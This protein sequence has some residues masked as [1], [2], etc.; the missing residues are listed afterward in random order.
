MAGLGQ[1]DFSAAKVA[2]FTSAFQLRGELHILGIMQTFLNDEQ[3]PTLTV[4]G[5]EAIGLEA[6]SPAR[7]SQP[8]IIVNKRSV[9]VILFEAMPP[10]GAISLLPR[11]ESLV[12]YLDRFAL[13][14]KF[15]MGQDARI[16]DFAD[17]SV[18]QFLVLSEAKMFPMFQ[19]RQGLATS[20]PLAVLHKS[21]IR[22]YHTA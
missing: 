1:P 9:Q 16:Q 4:F 19:A 18:Q 6:S 2:V 13:S 22:M 14:G 5:A 11:T 21:A 7:L 3:K 10:Q 17:A 15:F 8:E 12:V 20:A